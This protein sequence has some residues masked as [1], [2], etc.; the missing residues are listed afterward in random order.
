[1]VKFISINGR[2]LTFLWVLGTIFSMNRTREERSQMGASRLGEGGEKG[3]ESAWWLNKEEG[4]GDES[5]SLKSRR[6]VFAPR[7][8]C[9]IQ[10]HSFIILFHAS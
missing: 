8:T 9:I 1:M 10:Y 4:E 5:S 6:G 2:D 3:G 7:K